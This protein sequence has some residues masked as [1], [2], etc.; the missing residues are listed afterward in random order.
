MASRIKP[1]APP[2]MHICDHCGLPFGGSAII[3]EVENSKLLFCCYGCSFLHPLIGERNGEG[4]A[5]LFLLR[6]GISAFL[7]MNVMALSW[8]VYDQGWATLGME[9]AAIQVLSVLILVLSLPV[10]IIAGGPFFQN[11]IQEVHARRLSMDSLI[12]LG[13]FSAFGFSTYQALTGGT[14]FYFDTATMTLVFVTAGRYIEASAKT[15]SSQAIKRLLELQPRMARVVEGGTEKIIPTPEVKIGSIVRILPGERIPLDGILDEGFTSVNESVLTGESLPKRKRAG[16]ELYAA[17]VNIDGAVTM[18]VTAEEH[19]TLHGHIVR[20]VQEA[21]HSR[22]QSQLTG[23]RISA[24]FI[25]LVISL[26]ILTFGGWAIVSSFEAA[27]LHALSV[28]VVSCPCALGIGTPL[29][30]VNALFR[31]AE[32]GILVRSTSVFEKLATATTIAFD[33]TGTITNG[34]LTVKTFHSH[35]DEKTFLE[36]A[37]ALE[38]HSEHPI[39]KAIADFARSRN[40]HPPASKDVQAIPGK[41]II[42]KV[43]KNGEWIEVKIGTADLFG[44]AQ[45][46][47]NG[48]ILIGWEGCIR[49]RIEVK[50][51]L[52]TDAAQTVKDLHK[53]DVK[54]ILLSGDSHA[55]TSEIA[56][57]V[58]IQEAHAS[59]LPNEKLDILESAKQSGIT[60]MVGDGINDAPS[61]A[62]AD[63]G[64]TLASAT[65]IAKESADVTII[66]DH[67][68][69]IPSLIQFSR[70]V[71]KKIRWN[72][73]WAFGYNAVGISLAVVGL[74]QPII[75]A[76]AMVM[77]SVFIIV[78]S[79]RLRTT[80]FEMS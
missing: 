50:D 8:A 2:T 39:G 60:V 66:G 61:L 79:T 52:R 32:K 63:V 3:R 48:T 33:K 70:A 15:R 55:A 57:S 77:S 22:S 59:L 21:Q 16:D 56:K 23:D 12:A 17:T 51:T 73:L 35:I 27:L 69:R 62:A 34:K 65:D 37:A 44:L 28:L 76:A 11:M 68:H 80:T 24:L 7:A 40:V 41:G 19:D 36:R 14:K 72:L 13:T 4:N 25:P 53:L 45:T 43:R 58:G 9:P 71:V 1:P 29:V 31:V 67:L 10:M 54:T 26:S 6:L 78:N 20:L 18:R 74:L 38:Q 5:N 47:H 64:I 30:T 49:G 46:E 42:G 75:A